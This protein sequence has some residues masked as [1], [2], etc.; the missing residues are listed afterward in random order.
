MFKKLLIIFALIFS[1]SNNGNSD[2]LEDYLLKLLKSKKFV[3][4]YYLDEFSSLNITDGQYQ[5]FDKDG[6]K[7]IFDIMSNQPLEMEI[8]SFKILSRSDT[9][10][11]TSVTFEY[12]WIG[13]TGNTELNGAVEG[14]TILMKTDNS[15][16]AVYSAQTN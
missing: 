2:E 1:F 12:K 14:H 6:L 9:T 13:K 8:Q 10:N 16:V 4:E 15:W 11:F 3:S 5:V 7:E